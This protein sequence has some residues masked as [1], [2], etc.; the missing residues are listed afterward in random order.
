MKTCKECGLEFQEA[1]HSEIYCSPKCRGL[2][3]IKK[4][5]EKRKR[6][7]EA[8][9]AARQV[10]EKTCQFCGTKFSTTNGS[11]VY[12][13]RECS[14]KGILKSNRDGLKARR[15]RSPAPFVERK[16]PNCKMMFKTNHAT[17]KYCSSDC[18]NEMFALKANAYKH[19]VSDPLYE[20]EPIEDVLGKYG[21][22]DGVRFRP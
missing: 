19:A 15:T 22:S 2:V 6:N 4:E 3:L 20:Q 17:K 8:I 1:H 16:C 21:F 7:L 12:C 11:K 9:R 13:S 10:H 14:Y 18:Y 5:V